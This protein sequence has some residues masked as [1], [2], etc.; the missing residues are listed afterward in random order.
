MNVCCHVIWLPSLKAHICED[1]SLS[2]H[3][4]CLEIGCLISVRLLV[5]APLQAAPHFLAL[6]P[7]RYILQLSS[8]GMRHFTLGTLFGPELRSSKLSGNTAALL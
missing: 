8:N 2:C 6:R 4:A 1:C 7:G 5:V 3:P